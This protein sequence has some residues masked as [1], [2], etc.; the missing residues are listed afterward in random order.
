MSAMDERNCHRV[1]DPRRL[2]R[3]RRPLVDVPADRAVGWGI[4]A[5]SL[6]LSP[7]WRPPPVGVLLGVYFLVATINELLLHHLG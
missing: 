6:R 3:L 1:E 5:W 2:A 7:A 4:V